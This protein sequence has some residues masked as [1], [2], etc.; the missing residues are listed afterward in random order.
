M[1]F[2]ICTHRNNVLPKTR[3]H[4]SVSSNYSSILD[5]C[6]WSITAYGDISRKNDNVWVFVQ[7]I[8][9]L[10]LQ[11]PTVSMRERGENWER[12]IERE[13]KSLYLMVGETSCTA[14][15]D[16]LQHLI[17][18]VMTKAHSLKI[19]VVLLRW[20]LICVNVQPP[21]PPI[22]SLSL[23]PEIGKK[24]HHPLCPQTDSDQWHLISSPCNFVVATDKK[25]KTVFM[26]AI[27]P[28]AEH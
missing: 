18:T 20:A 14:S 26:I 8:M 25:I 21:L 28:P 4:K 2:Y 17:A 19:D 9:T 16:A 1:C 5:I 24:G 12:K 3:M 7:P 15:R 6:N 13:R 10:W 27:F 22:M 23:R 11:W